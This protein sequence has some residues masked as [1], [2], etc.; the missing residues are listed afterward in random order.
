MKFQEGESLY[1]QSE[2]GK[3]YWLRL[4]PGMIRLGGLG[5]INGDRILDLSDGS[6]ITI[7]GK[8][9]NAFRPG[10]EEFSQALDRGAQIITPKDACEILFE[11]DVKA[12]DR[13]I[14]VGAG[15]GGLTTALLR[16]V[17][18]TGF[19]HTVELFEKNA[20]KARKNVMKTGLEDLWE[21]QIGDAR[22]SEIEFDDA[23]VLTTDMPDVELALDNLLP[24]LRLGGRMCAYMPNANQLE[25]A[26][27]GMREHGMAD[28]RA[29]EIL[30]R[31]IEVGP[32]GVRPSFQMLG[33]TGYLAFGRKR[34]L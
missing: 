25:K 6:A 27:N 17:A 32:G 4:Q 24:H 2:D 31:G 3:R 23:D 18:P 29:M 34:E 10:Q 5:A 33:H 16:A 11:C 20:D 13:V 28:V 7:A 21:C 12:G 15:S 9:F 26:V 14:E 30:Q 22:E 19:V 8:R 1:L